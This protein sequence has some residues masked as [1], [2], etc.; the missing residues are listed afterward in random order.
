MFGVV[1]LGGWIELLDG[2]VIEHMDDGILDRRELA[3]RLQA[4]KL[5]RQDLIANAIAGI[6]EGAFDDL[7]RFLAQ[8]VTRS[9]APTE[10]IEVL[11]QHFA[12]E[13]Q[14]AQGFLDGAQSVDPWRTVRGGI[15][16][17]S[18]GKGKA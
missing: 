9:N 10:G 16:S 4:V 18:G 1:L 13:W 14:C 15:K 8:F 17:C 12:V 3:R 2:E 5:P 6:L 11:A 7:Q